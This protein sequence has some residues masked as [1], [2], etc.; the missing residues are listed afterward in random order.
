MNV[1]LVVARYNEDLSWV[2]STN[3]DRYFIYNKGDTSIPNEILLPNIGREAHTFCY[4]LAHNY[5]DMGDYT[6]FCQGGSLAHGGNI[7]LELINSVKSTSSFDFMWLTN[8]TF[9]S[10]LTGKPHHHTTLYM[11]RFFQRVGLL[12]DDKNVFQFAPGAQ[13]IVNK[14][15]VHRLP[16]SFYFKLLE[17]FNLDTYDLEYKLDDDRDNRSHDQYYNLAC[18]FER[19]WEKIFKSEII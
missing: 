10:D 13:F 12:V 2:S 17:Q 19:V 7:I 3:V 18:L 16:Q 8:N 4:H 1:D 14:K 15:L 11:E 9:D 5:N 6:A